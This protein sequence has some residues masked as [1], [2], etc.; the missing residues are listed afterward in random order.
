MSGN[1]TC[2]LRIG[3]FELRPDRGVL[4]YGESSFHLEPKVCDVLCRLARHPGDLVTREVLLDDVWGR[5]YGADESLTRAVSI[6]RKTFK[7]DAERLY[8][9]TVPK[10]GYRL[11]A[12][13]AELTAADRVEEGVQGYHGHA[14]EHSVLPLTPPPGQGGRAPTSGTLTRPT[15]IDNRILIGL[16]A[17]LVCLTIAFASILFWQRPAQAEAAEVEP[18]RTDDVV[19]VG[20]FAAVGREDSAGEASFI[21]DQLSTRMASM[22]SVNGVRAVPFGS[23]VAPTYQVSGS[24]EAN[25]NTL[26]ATLGL[27]A[28]DTGEVIWSTSVERDPESAN[29]LATE[30]GAR[31]AGA[32]G[33]ALGFRD[34]GETFTPALLSRMLLICDGLRMSEGEALPEH[35]RAVRQEDPNEARGLALSAILLSNYAV[36]ML[37]PESDEYETVKQ[38]A[39]E[40][41]A[42]AA[43][44]SEKKSLASVAVAVTLPQEKLLKREKMLAWSSDAQ[45]TARTYALWRRAGFYREVGRIADAIN[46]YNSILLHDPNHPTASAELA[47]LHRT[48]GRNGAARRRLEETLR[49]DPDNMI[50]LQRRFMLEVQF[51]NV[52]E[53]LTLLERYHGGEKDDDRSMEVCIVPFLEIRRQIEAG[54]QDETFASQIQ[55]GCAGLEDHFLARLWATIGFE[56][57]AM[58]LLR[59]IMANDPTSSKVVLYYPEFDTLR[60]RPE[61]WS[62]FQSAGLPEYW[63]ESDTWPDFCRLEDLGY[64]C[65]VM[66]QLAMQGDA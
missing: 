4:L 9:E 1:A 14:A 37:K 46:L 7:S 2:A 35:A 47:W 5:S 19:A 62:L 61:I 16:I 51:G 26:L 28:L 48:L 33:C 23:P 45:G 29:E 17:L 58:G 24:V 30:V 32:L 52:D 49:L 20:E 22:L 44:M 56:N 42:Q 59:K 8:I 13:V 41:A 66:A 63:I 38:E 6:L 40:M 55:E 53:A 27:A 65:R 25:G 18:D 57:E 64:E 31:F 34:P 43:E 15:T 39:Q 3:A 12:P 54:I 11:V 10:K 60:R 50:A 21:A 36:H